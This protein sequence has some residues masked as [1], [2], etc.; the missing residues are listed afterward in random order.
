VDL[1]T[2]TAAS[3]V[4]VG[5]TLR[6]TTVLRN[7]TQE[8]LP[9]TMAVVGL[10]A[11]LSPQPWQLK[12]LQEKKTVDFYEVSGS[13]VVFYYRQMK[14]GEEKTIQ[15]DC[16]AEIPGRYTAPASRAYLYYTNEDKVWTSLTPINVFM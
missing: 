12:E 2:E 10:P 8:G 15:L 4:K 1:K 11:G 3:A 6:I 5:Q 16:K 14:P 13:S 9:M 7:K